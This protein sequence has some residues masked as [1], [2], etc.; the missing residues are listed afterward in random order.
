M[1][2]P[3]ATHDDF[4]AIT[5][6]FNPMRYA[7]RRSNFRIFRERLN[8]PLIAVELAYGDE[9]ELKEQDADILIQLRGSAI[10]WQKERLLNLGLRALPPHCRNV[11]W[12]DCD[13]IFDKAD[14]AESVK[15]LLDR[16]A[17][18]QMFSRVNYLAAHWTP[19]A[20]GYKETDFELRYR[21]WELESTLIAHG[22]WQ[23]STAISRRR[24]S[25]APPSSSASKVPRSRSAR[26]FR[27]SSGRSSSPRPRRT[28]R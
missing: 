27:A 23:A 18:V 15:A 13:I 12:V 11:A 26:S 9:F 28:L 22:R 25:R 1:A 2:L 20:N 19:E 5:S 3:T 24:R 14:W 10:L 6:Y 4:W 16:C 17:L 7:R 21:L 8:V